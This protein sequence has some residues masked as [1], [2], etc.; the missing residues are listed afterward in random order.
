MPI[1]STLLI[2]FSVPI[3]F[4]Y[5]VFIVSPVLLIIGFTVTV[6]DCCIAVTVNNFQLYNGENK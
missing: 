6:S 2:S 4:I 1:V 5:R 3:E